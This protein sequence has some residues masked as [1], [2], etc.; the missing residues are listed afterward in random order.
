MRGLAEI[1]ERHVTDSVKGLVIPEFY[2]RRAD[3][4]GPALLMLTK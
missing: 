2:P 1:A 3:G 4:D